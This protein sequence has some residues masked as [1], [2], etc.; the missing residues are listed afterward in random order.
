MET[1]PSPFPKRRQRRSP[2]FSA[3]VYCGQTARSIK[4]PLGMEVGL[5]PGDYV[6][7]GD[8][9]PTPKGRSTTQFSAHVYCGQTAAWIKMPLGT[10]VGLA[11]CFQC[12][13]SYPQEK[14]HTHPHLIFSPCL[15]WPN[16][17]MDEDAAWYGSRP[18]LRPHCIRRGPSSRE[19]GKA[20]PLFGQCLLC[21]R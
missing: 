7:D 8:P 11:T 9:A 12:G 20:A 10:E 15:L 14:G 16:G 5:S 2:Q 13:P 4:M 19:R 17:W 3:H 21:P 18:Q 6:L 1:Q